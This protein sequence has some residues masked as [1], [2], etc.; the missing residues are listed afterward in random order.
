MEKNYEKQ[1]ESRGYATN[2]KIV[3]KDLPVRDSNGNIQSGRYVSNG[4]KITVLDIGYT[5]QLVLVEY[6]TASG[7]REGYISNDRDA[8][9]YDNPYNWVNGSTPETVY[10]SHEGGAEL[11][12]L[13]P[14]EKA[15]LL[16]KKGSR[17]HVAYDTP[18]KGPL[19]KSGYVNYHG[20]IGNESGGSSGENPWPNVTPGGVVSGGFTFPNNAKLVGGSLQLKD[21]NGNNVPGTVSNG[22]SITVLDVG[23]TKQLALVQYPVSGGVKQGYI[24]NNTN[25]IKY[26]NPYN[27]TN[28]ASSEPVYPSPT[29]NDGKFGT[30]SPY[31]S[32]T[33][34]YKAGN[35]YHVVYDTDKG[36]LSKSGYV[37]YEGKS[38][39]DTSI[40]IP[41]VSYSGVTYES[42][43]SSGKGRPLHLYK[44]GS[45]SKILF[46]G[47]AIH[48]WED[49]W[50][51]D[52]LALVKIANELVKKIGA[53]NNSDGLNGWTVYIA[54]CMNPDGVIVNGT[55]NGPGRCAVT[56]GIDLNRCFPTGFTVLTTPRNRT[57]NT[58][59]GAPEAVALKNL[60][61]RLH[62]QASKLIVIDG[63]GW[64]NC[65]YGN[66]TIA[67]YFTK[68]FG[69]SYKGTSG[70]GFFSRWAE[71]LP[72]AS[73]ILLEY[74]TSTYS[75]SDVER[76]D[77]VGKTYRAMMNIIGASTDSGNGGGSNSGNGGGSNSG[78]GNI[79]VGSKVKITGTNWAT[80]Q[81][82][83]DWAKNETYTVSK[84]DGDRAL[85]QEVT[86]WIYLKDIV[87]VS[88]GGSSDSG[89]GGGSNSGN[90]NIIVGS[91]VKITGTNWAIG[92]LI[93]DWAKNE[94]YTV[95]KIDGDRALLQEV[96][97]WIYLKDIVLVSGGGSS[98]SGLKPGEEVFNRTGKIINVSTE[99]NVRSGPGTSYSAIGK[100]YGG[101]KVTIVSRIKPS[102]ESLYWYKINYGSGEGYI[103]SDFVELDPN[104]GSS[105]DY[106]KYQQFIAVGRILY[107]S[108]IYDDPNLLLGGW[109]SIKGDTDVF[110]YEEFDKSYKILYQSK[111][112]FVPKFTVHDIRTTIKNSDIESI[113]NTFI[114]AYQGPDDPL[115]ELPEAD[116]FT[117]SS[118]SFYMRNEYRAWSD[119]NGVNRFTRNGDKFFISNKFG[120]SYVMSTDMARILVPSKSSTFKEAFRLGGS[121]ALKD[122]LIYIGVAISVVEDIISYIEERHSKNLKVDWKYIVS[123]IIS[124]GTI[125][126]IIGLGATALGTA[127][128]TLTAL[129]FGLPI[130]AGSLIGVLIGTMLGMT[131][132]Y[133][134]DELKFS[135]KI[136]QLLISVFSGIENLITAR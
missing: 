27:W 70:G 33:K 14:R 44:I 108:T 73:S 113:R 71:T 47:F 75:Y 30:L 52:G 8:I 25:I 78:N 83:P 16:Y 2:A 128:G 1:I 43:G 130:L 86:S 118:T 136:R 68:E 115:K 56:T 5:K 82:I 23:Y 61:E 22:D 106:P 57:G 12:S 32:A 50:S 133:I 87:L 100:L 38:F 49:N 58:P 105:N 15:T 124:E 122:F 3:G 109:I 24:Q 134:N 6:P 131:F 76:G 21:A 7:V 110:I 67:S 66:S 36:V 72:K 88:G 53:K 102:G 60:I 92:Q 69:F 37:E 96:T 26:N 129:I 107:T 34:L 59:L 123:L 51:N 39:G 19:S 10:L 85:L 13:D 114:K 135:E 18:S 101:N 126:T 17:Y 120:Q 65:T 112:V 31:E 81:L 116:F 103:R 91:K 40:T 48:G 79:I 11:G 4:D 29:S 77:Y 45:G 90:G 62:S 74:P 121:A 95:S 99:L 97:S 54:S 125:G 84:I 63:H 132:T 41:T 28:G 127:I 46:A 55:N 117:I 20:G 9:K 93:P 104:S 94:T 35:R 64:L 111:Y 119:K 42:Y 89:N 80:G 98:D